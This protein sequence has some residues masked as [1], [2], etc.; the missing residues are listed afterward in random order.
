MQVKLEKTHCQEKK[1]NRLKNKRDQLIDRKK[2]RS[3]YRQQ[4]TRP[5]AVI[6][7]IWSYGIELWG[8]GSTFNLVITQ[9]SQSKILRAIANANAP[10]YVTNHTLRTD[11]NVIHAKINKNHN[12]PETHHS[13]LLEPLLQPVNTRRL[14]ADSHIAHRSHAAPLPF[15]CH[16]VPLRV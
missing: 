7:Q 12:K 15:P 11:F 13:P 3:I 5:Q 10:R 8:C 4:I 1:T 9:R 6:K 2:I 16:A 14:K